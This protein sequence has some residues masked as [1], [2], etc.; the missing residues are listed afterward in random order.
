MQKSTSGK[1]S[2]EQRDQKTGHNFAAIDLKLP[3][4][5]VTCLIAKKTLNRCL[6]LNPFHVSWRLFVVVVLFRSRVRPDADAAEI[7]RVGQKMYALATEMP[8]FVSY[9]DFAASDGESLTLVEFKSHATLLAWRNHPE[10]QQAQELAREAF[11]EG[12]EITVCEA[13]RAY[14][15]TRADGRTEI[16]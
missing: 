6:F 5:L 16:L 15:F 11:F 4:Q 2:C 12:Y 14:R 13:R 7:E 8:G 1:Q 9:K 10:H 3:R